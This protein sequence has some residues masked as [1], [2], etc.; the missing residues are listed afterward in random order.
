M[1]KRQL[2]GLAE[3]TDMLGISKPLV[4]ISKQ[5]AYTITNSKTFPEPIQRLRMGPVWDRAEVQAWID[6]R[7]K[8]GTR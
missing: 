1:A 6:K 5:R 7:N 8:E 4:G 3:V 2:V